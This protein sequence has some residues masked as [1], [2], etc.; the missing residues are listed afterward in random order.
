VCI[1]FTFVNAFWTFLSSGYPFEPAIGDEEK[2]NEN[3]RIAQFDPVA[4]AWLSLYA[5][6]AIWCMTLKFLGRMCRLSPNSTWSVTSR[7]DKHD[8]IVRVVRV[9]L[10]SQHAHCQLLSFSSVN[11]RLDLDQARPRPTSSLNHVADVFF[12]GAIGHYNRRIMILTCRAVRVAP[13]CPTSVTRLVLSRYDFS[14]CENACRD[15]T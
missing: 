11:F 10:I 6:G 7:H 15:V 12:F 2:I 8:K 1:N 9:W 13:C 14:L 4:V 3:N 5:C